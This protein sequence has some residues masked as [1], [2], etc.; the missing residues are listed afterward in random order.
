MVTLA[1]LKDYLLMVLPFPS[2]VLN[3]GGCFPHSQS[4]LHSFFHELSFNLLSTSI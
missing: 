4:H 2:L 1:I 3:D